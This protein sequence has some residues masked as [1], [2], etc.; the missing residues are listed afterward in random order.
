MTPLDEVDRLIPELDSLKRGEEAAARLVEYGPIAIEPLRR[1]LLEGK[2]SNIFQPRMWAVKAL[3]SLGAKDVLLEYLFQT[4]EIPDPVDRFGEEAVASTAA[5]SL[6]AWPSAEM[7]H[8]LLELA[9]RR[10]LPG[11]IEALAEY[12]RPE[13]I[14]YF[15]RALEDDFYR[16]AA[17]EAF[18]K[19]GKTACSALALSAV[20]PRPN[21]LT[22]TPSSLLRRR[23]ALGLLSLIGICAEHWQI[24]RV[25]IHDPDAHLVAGVAKLGIGL[26]SNEERIII[27]KRLLGLLASA[28]WYLQE[29]IED[30]LV[31]LQDESATDIETEIAW[32]MEQPDT[33][34]ATDER[35]WA[36]LKLKR[37]VDGPCRSRHPPCCD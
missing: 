28:P 6:A 30:S 10:L 13:T 34:R 16:P 31:A 24:L 7:Y 8:A 15:E 35:L 32:R 19:L 22:E 33:V 23:S 12:Q 17:E 5:Q 21:L 18:Q 2:P 26:A 36:L 37:R 3:A 11:L 1:F 27:A 25:L 14:P 4:R 20:T 9:Q 29:D